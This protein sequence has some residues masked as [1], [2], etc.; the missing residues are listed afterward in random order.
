MSLALNTVNDAYGMLQRLGAPHRLICHVKLVGEAAE[1]LIAKLRQL[2][3][4]VDEHFVRLGV[5]FHDA[6]KI[7]HPE[8]LIAKGTNHE[9]VG[10]KLLIA[11]GV[12]PSL[13]RCCRSHGQWDTMDCCFEELLVAL[14]D[15]LWKGKR[16]AQL[17]GEVIQRIAALGQKDYWELFVEMDGCF[18]AIAA[19]G[20][21]RLLRSQI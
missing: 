5:A 9:A 16:N 2:Q 21:V 18:E 4:P 7:L 10:E 15:T 1:V 8:E 19:K 13:A 17:E 12:D 3:V 20:D 11:N 6:G 14:A